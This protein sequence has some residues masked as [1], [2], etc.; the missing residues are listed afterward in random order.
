MNEGD[1][2]KARERWAGFVPVWYDELDG[3]AL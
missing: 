2:Q 3:A 1:L